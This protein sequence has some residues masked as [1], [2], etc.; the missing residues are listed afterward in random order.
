M[1]VLPTIASLKWPPVITP[2]WNTQLQKTVTGRVVA[3]TYQQY[4][5]YTFKIQYDYLSQT[6]FDTILGFFNGQGGNLTP[7][8]FNAGAGNN[9]VTT[10]GIGTGDG[11]T[12]TFT[13]LRSKGGYVEPVAASFGSPIAYDNGVSAAA[14]F[15]S[16]GNGQ[17]TYTTAPAA[18]HSLTWSG[19]YYFQV[20]FSKGQAEIEEFMS[21]LYSMKQI[22]LETYFP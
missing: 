12:K 3:A 4:A 22:E 20:R 1:N 9:S 21:Q 18:G 2:V 13:L 17:V 14:T 5:L 7:F 6:D 16:P 11:S 8:L 15:N 10:Q 19:S